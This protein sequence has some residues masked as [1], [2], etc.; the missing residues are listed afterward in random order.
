MSRLCLMALAVPLLL[1]GCIGENEDTGFSDCPSHGDDDSVEVLFDVDVSCS[2]RSSIS[3][4]E[5]YVRE[6]CIAAFNDGQLAE[7]ACIGEGEDVCLELNSGQIYDI[8]MMANMGEVHPDASEQEFCEAFEYR[9][10]SLTEFEECLPMVWIGNDVKVSMGMPAV[11]A[12]LVRLVSK[13]NFKIDKSALGGLEVASVRMRQSPR[14]VR[15]FAY[16]PHGSMA[17]STDDVFDGDYGSSEDLEILNSGGEIVFYTL[18]NCQGTL[19]PDNQNP[20]DKVPDNLGAEGDLC[21]YLELECV[22]ADP[23][24]VGDVI[25]RFYLGTDN[26]TNFDVIRNSF[27]DVT[28]FLTKDALGELSWRVEPDVGFQGDHARGYIVEGFHAADDLYVGEKF[29]YELELDTLLAEHV[30]NDISDCSLMIRK[31]DALLDLLELSDYQEVVSNVYDVGVTCVGQGE[32]TLCLC[33]RKGNVLA[34]LGRMKIALPRVCMSFYYPYDDGSVE[35]FDEPPLCPINGEPLVVYAY[36]VDSEGYNLNRKN[37]YALD[38]FNFSDVSRT[39]SEYE[40]SAAF[41]FDRTN[42]VAGSGLYAARYE[43]RCVNAGTD[44]GLNAALLR[45]YDEQDPIVVWYEEENYGLQATGDCFVNLLPAEISIVEDDYYSLSVY[46]PSN[47]PV[48]ILLYHAVYGTEDASLDISEELDYIDVNDVDYRSYPCVVYQGSASS[49]MISSAM[50]IR[51]ERNSLGTPYREDGENLLYR[52]PDEFYDDAEVVAALNGVFQ[53]MTG[54]APAA[55]GNVLMLHLSGVNYRSTVTGPSFR[56]SLYTDCDRLLGSMWYRG[57]GV[58]NQNGITGYDFPV[59]VSNRCYADIS[60]ADL[61]YYTE[62]IWP[63]PVNVHISYDSENDLITISSPDNAIGLKVNTVVS[64]DAYGSV[65]VYP[66]GTY[67]SSKTYTTNTVLGGPAD[68]SRKGI[69]PGTVPV[70][71]DGGIVK[72]AMDIIYSR[73]EKDTKNGLGTSS[74]QHRYHPTKVTYSISMTFDRFYPVEI[75]SDI[76]SIDY[77][78]SQD[79]KTYKVAMELESMN[80]LEFMKVFRNE[81]Y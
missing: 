21:T 20:S 17:C 28:L 29:L 27:I 16:L 63:D 42:G 70:A 18:E 62:G 56:I 50:H 41:T 66:K 54:D 48:D 45:M 61:W 11:S 32:G 75:T 14:A 5:T 9:I 30:G 65:K 13:V 25:Y 73:S 60:P 57:T 39:D 51:S 8:Y 35:S 22:F 69:V 53:G 3:P 7:Y 6:I 49:K 74:Y 12:S 47:T 26:C 59:L 79:A 10:S 24:Y 43:C 40:V 2:A 33:D 72:S 34:E 1:Y 38:L 58:R 67:F 36:L 81:S 46:N 77:Y 4:D 64:A 55:G 44:P 76:G 52:I 80:T 68:Y 31:G 15:P 23:L 19:L 37:M 78:H 71:I